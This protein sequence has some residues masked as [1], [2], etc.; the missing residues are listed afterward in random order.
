MEKHKKQWEFLKRKFEANQLSHAYLFSGAEDLGKK[1]FAKEFVKLVNCS[2]ETGTNPCQKCFSCQSIEKESF[3]DFKILREANEKDSKFGD[4][5]EI[6]ISQ[7]RDVQKFLNYKPYYGKFKAV[8]VEDAEKMNQEAQS[9]FLKT[10]EEPNGNAIVILLSSKP[11]LLLETILSRSQTIKFFG[12]KSLSQEKIDRQNKILQE[13][14]K[15]IPLSFSEKFKYA[16][17]FDFEKQKLQEFLEVLQ[18]YF[19]HLMFTKVGVSNDLSND[20]QKQNFPL[21]NYSVLKIKKNIKLI[22]EI[23]IKIMFS[24]VNQKLALEVLLM[25]L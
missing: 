1:F 6:K 16:K 9:C 4:G 5:G 14:L 8:L 23:Q 12:R 17:S 13:V 2:A 19:R 20:F 15:I 24:N 25:Q 22:E 3:P 11:G 10:L 18:K 7:I 21:N